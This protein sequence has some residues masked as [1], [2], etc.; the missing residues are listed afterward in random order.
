[1]NILKGFVSLPALANNASGQTAYFGELS[2]YA[3]TFSRTKSN[4]TKPDT[5]PGVEVIAFTTKNDTGAYITPSAT[6]ANHILTVAYWVYQQHQAGMIPSNASKAAFIAD[7]VAPGN[8][9]DMTGVEINEIISGASPTLRMP[10]YVKWSFTSAGVVHDIKIWFSD[11]RFRSQ[12]DE[13][14]IVVVPPITP[15]NGLNASTATVS[16]LLAA[17]TYGTMQQ[18][19]NTAVN[20]IPPTVVTPYDVVW[21]D[22]GAPGSTRTTTWMA[23]VYGQAGNDSDNLK[24]AISQYIADNSAL[25]VWDDIYPDL[26]AEN[27]YIVLPLWGELGV[28]E[29]GLDVELYRGAA[30]TDSA[31]AIAAAN[32]PSSYALSVDLPTYLS[33][34]LCMVSAFWRS[35]QLLIVGN[36]NNVDGDFNFVTKYP[37][38]LAVNTGSPDFLRMTT[39]TRNFVAALNAALQHA[40]ALTQVSPIPVGYSRVIRNNK[41]YLAFAYGGFNYLVLAKVSYDSV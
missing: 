25:S 1:M 2:T 11:T 37:D 3:S 34:N 13:F 7:M 28:P 15:I 38:Y 6:V 19:I 39:A 18:R 36:P 24:A 23:V 5:C 9:P 17:M 29:A 41:V 32:L 21:H 16:L 31:S 10:D 22:P 33:A 26:Y 12:Y 4:F 27:E 40:L 20:N 8:N 30:R 35:I 14:E